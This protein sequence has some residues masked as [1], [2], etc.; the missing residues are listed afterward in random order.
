[1]NDKIYSLDDEIFKLRKQYLDEYK[2]VNES[3]SSV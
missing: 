3:T 2:Y 1:M